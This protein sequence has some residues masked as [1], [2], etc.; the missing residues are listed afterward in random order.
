MIKRN[1]IACPFHFKTPTKNI[2]VKNENEDKL[3]SEVIGNFSY[4]SPFKDIGKLIR[5]KYLVKI[6]SRFFLLKFNTQCVHEIWVKQMNFIVR[7]HVTMLMKVSWSGGLWKHHRT[8]NDIIHSYSSTMEQI[9][10]LTSYLS[11]L[12]LSSQRL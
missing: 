6:F 7:Y 10:Q 5:F 8:V 9:C 3:M 1:T 12:P 4:I 11:I 2:Q